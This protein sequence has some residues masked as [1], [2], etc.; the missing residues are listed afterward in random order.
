MIRSIVI[1]T[2]LMTLIFVSFGWA[3]VPPHIN[4]QGRLLDNQGNPVADD[5]Y[6]LTFAIYDDP[7]TETS[8]WS[9]TK[10]V[11]VTGGLFNVILGDVTPFE[12]LFTLGGEALFM[13]IKVG[14]D[15][16]LEPRTPINSSPFAMKSEYSDV[17]GHAMGVG[18]NAIEGFNIVDGS[19]ELIDLGQNGA[20]EGQVIKWNGASW[21]VANDEVSGGWLDE[22]GFL[23]LFDETDSVLI[24][25]GSPSAILNVYANNVCSTYEAAVYIESNCYEP[26]TW[27]PTYGL[28]CNHAI[29][30]GGAAIYGEGHDQSDGVFGKALGSYEAQ[31]G[32]RG[33][34]MSEIGGG[35]YG[36]CS[37]G[38]GIHGVSSTGYAGYFE[39]KMYVSGNLGIGTSNPTRRLTVDSG[40]VL[41]RGEDGWNGAG[42]MA[43][44][45]MGDPN[46]DIH[47]I[48]G[49]GMRFKT[50]GNDEHN[51]QFQNHLGDTLMTIGANGGVGIASDLDSNASLMVR[52]VA[53]PGSVA[54][55]GH[56]SVIGTPPLY[57]GAG[58]GGQFVSDNIAGFGVTGAAFSLSGGG[59]MIGVYG[60]TNSSQGYAIYGEGGMAATGP[61]ST[62]NETRD[63]GYRQSYSTQAT[64][65]WCEDFG[66][67]QL[68]DGEAII[69]IEDIFVQITNLDEGYHVFLTPLGSC[70]LYVAEKNS[71]SFIVK[72]IDN[73]AC[74]IEFDYRIVARRRGYE[75]ERL[76]VVEKMD[77]IQQVV[78]NYSKEWE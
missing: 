38:Y 35:V 18:E 43:F 5:V 65:N 31:Y 12:D 75:Q 68:V 30:C 45:F 47:S 52:Q 42:D 37:P 36:E 72:A 22:G 66:Q 59:A 51:F 33:I 56:N 41:I 28:H 73:D 58:V 3:V 62:I 24:G 40:D 19:I 64:G 4:Y 44:L 29:D 1:G 14:A 78:E 46:H 26:Y 13:G 9:E 32:V 49:Q 2:I 61:I 55:Y 77:E 21:M 23:K 39:G 27:A 8:L 20:T 7:F 6:Q 67:G 60:T 63:Y 10:N 15:P 50:L 54:I 11:E 57:G 34:G 48:Y 70:N 17:S 16:E 71:G 74:S 69:N 53:Y 25:N 76:K